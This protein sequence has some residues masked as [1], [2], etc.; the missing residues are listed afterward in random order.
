MPVQTDVDNKNVIIEPSNTYL[1]QSSYP[2]VVNV[3]DG[4][5]NGTPVDLTQFVD[6]IKGGEVYS[7][8]DINQ[9]VKLSWQYDSADPTL[10]AISGVEDITLHQARF[11]FTANRFQRDED[12]AALKRSWA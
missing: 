1:N 10:E 7:R 11:T 8:S 9:L 4:F 5:Y 12:Q 6:L 3:E 2:S